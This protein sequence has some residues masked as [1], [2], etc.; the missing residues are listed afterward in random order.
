[1]VSQPPLKIDV[2]NTTFSEDLNPDPETHDP[3]FETSEPKRCVLDLPEPGVAH[4]TKHVTK[5]Y[6]QDP[7]GSRYGICISMSLCIYTFS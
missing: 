5:S 4:T 1:M 2:L 6:S 7:I 3:S